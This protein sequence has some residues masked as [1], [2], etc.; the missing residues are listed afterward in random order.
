[1]KGLIFLLLV[2]VLGCK[3]NKI[4]DTNSSSFSFDVNNTSYNWHF[5][6]NSLSGDGYAIT[7]KYTGAGGAP[8]G[9]RLSGFNSSQ[10]V[11][12]NC[13]METNSLIPTTY[14]SITTSSTGFIQSSYIVNGINYAPIN[15]ND[16]MVV[17]ISNVSNNQISG[18]FN[19]VMHDVNTRAIKLEIKY[20]IFTNILVSN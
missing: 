1:M 2:V 13:F 9:Y 12:L 5:N 16:S 14:K 8:S 15:I 10:D 11:T 18:T 4:Q 20:G 3:K 6:F 19:A 7:T 17:T